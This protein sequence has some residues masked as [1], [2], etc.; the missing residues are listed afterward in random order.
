MV[1]IFS[2]SSK[3]LTRYVGLLW[4]RGCCCCC[5]LV[6]KP[7]LTLCDPTDW[8]PPGT[9]VHEMLQARILEWIAI[10]CSRGSS[11]PRDP[12]HVSCLAG[13]L[14]TT[15]LHGKPHDPGKRYAKHPRLFE[16]TLK[17]HFQSFSKSSSAVC[18]GASVLDCSSISSRLPVTCPP[19][20]LCR[21]CCLLYFLFLGCWICYF[22]QNEKQ[23]ICYL[24]LLKGTSKS[25]LYGSYH[26]NLLSCYSS[27]YL[28][29]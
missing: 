27:E 6:A 11:P 1:L 3:K 5:R 22:K 25:L 9:S 13:R 12:T 18:H 2:I 10:S 19:S 28:L 21:G 29:L 15:E 26:I 4:P 14:F 24:S 16:L 17:L 8:S 20:A 7:C 23:L